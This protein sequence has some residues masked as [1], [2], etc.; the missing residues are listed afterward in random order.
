MS[1]INRYYDKKRE[2]EAL[3]NEVE[4]LEK[5]PR[6]E[7]EFEFKNALEALLKEHNKSAQEMAA[8][9]SSIDP[10][11]TAAKSGKAGSVRPKRPLSVY[12]NPKT[13]EVVETRGG[14]HKTLKAWRE[15]YGAET[16]KGW[17]QSV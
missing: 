10:S 8:V 3:A 15:E 1:L 13:G 14:N 6:L 17:K 2:L 4:A 11:I 12:K 9:L 16:V 7:E 5:D